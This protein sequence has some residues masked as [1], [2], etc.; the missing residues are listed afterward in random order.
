MF[1]LIITAYQIVGVNVLARGDVALRKTND[2]TVLA[3]RLAIA[4]GLQCN[5]MT[6]RNSGRRGDRLTAMDQFGTTFQRPLQHAHMIS[7]AKTQQNR[8]H[9]HGSHQGNHSGA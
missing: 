6:G 3:H 4:D 1:P 8:I 9:F 5:F 7:F 2:L